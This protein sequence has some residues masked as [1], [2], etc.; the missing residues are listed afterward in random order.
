MKS[1]SNRNR[2][3]I[4]LYSD[5][6]LRLGCLN[7]L[8]QF[9]DSILVTEFPKSGGTWLSEML[10]E[11]TD[12]PFPQNRLPGIRSSIFHGHYIHKPLNV[13]TIVLWRDPRDI[14]VSWYFHCL[15]AETTNTRFQQES[16]A[17]MSFTD[18]SNIKDNLPEFIKHMFT[19]QNTPGFTWNDFYDRW[20]T[21]HSNT[22][23]TSYEQLKNSPC[24]ALQCIL[25]AFGYEVVAESVACTVESH[26]FLTKSGRKVG[27]TNQSSFMR[28]GVV[29]DWKNSFSPVATS[30]F[31][32]YTEDR[33]VRY[34]E[35]TSIHIK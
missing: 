35:F 34:Q 15:T 17:S 21:T 19:D 14:V 24:E 13:N 30:I 33:L 4:A 9:N 22:V 10:S 26:S 5:A 29:G 18:Y 8:S 3:R 2:T 20:S 27:T 16:R 31:N 28:K 32:K 1:P 12:L 6:L 7:V 25:K 11:L 23:H